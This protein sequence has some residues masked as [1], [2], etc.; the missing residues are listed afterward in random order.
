MLS[1]GD[2]IYQN[3]DQIVR[4]GSLMLG[5]VYFLPRNKVFLCNFECSMSEFH[6]EK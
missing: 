3:Q 1:K 6:A 5:F 4:K 2:F